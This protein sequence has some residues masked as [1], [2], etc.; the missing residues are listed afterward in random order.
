MPLFHT[1]SRRA[2][3]VTLCLSIAV[4]SGFLLSHYQPSFS[5]A[6]FSVAEKKGEVRALPIRLLSRNEPMSVDFTITNTFFAPKTWSIR[7]DDCLQSLVINNIL[8]PASM[9]E[10]CEIDRWKDIDLSHYMHAG[11]N[12]VRAIVQET[13]GGEQGFDIRLARFDPASFVLRTLLILSLIAGVSILLFPLFVRVGDKAFFWII[14]SAVVA[15]FVYLDGTDMYTRGNDLHGHIDYILY[16]LKDWSIPPIHGGWQFYHPPLYYFLAAV[17]TKTGLLLFDSQYLGLRIA[18]YFSTVLSCIEVYVLYLISRLL[19]PAL[20]DRI[21]R[22]MW[23]LLAATVPSLIYIGAQLNNDVLL[24]FLIIVDL[25]LLLRFWRAAS[26]RKWMLIVIIAACAILTKSN[27]ILL[28]PALLATVFFHPKMHRRQKIVAISTAFFIV[29][30]L[31]YW[32]QVIRLNEDPDLRMVGNIN[33][34]NKNLMVPNAPVLYT[35][36]NPLRIVDEPFVE[37]WSGGEE[38]GYFL[39]HYFRSVLFGEEWLREH[40]L[41]ARVLTVSMLCILLC[42][43]LVIFVPRMIDWKVAAPLLFVSASLFAGHIVFRWHY[44][45]AS[46]QHARYT[47]PA[48]FI[49]FYFAV[50]FIS[51]IWSSSVRKVMYGFLILAALS[52]AAVVIQFT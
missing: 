41:L 36:F 50:I 11:S 27:G 12:S 20:K 8:L 6:V 42:A 21:M 5:E 38:R 14:L 35:V 29:L 13:T 31:T 19:F 2:L 26:M 17:V 47:I 32:L 25:Y 1:R 16:V 9:F 34:L 40:M 44:P 52:S 43:C 30:I 39:E 22:A 28:L 10:P 3:L 48:V 23:F 46:S 7:A 33:A 37:N 49:V 18:Q 24:H 4:L 51:Q 15:R 45:F